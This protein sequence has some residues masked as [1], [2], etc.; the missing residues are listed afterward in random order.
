[1]FRLKYRHHQ[2]DDEK[3]KVYSCMGLRL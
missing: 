2:A 3:E 1:M